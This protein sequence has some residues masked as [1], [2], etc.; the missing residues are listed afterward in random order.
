[1]NTLKQWLVSPEL[2]QDHHFVS[3]GTSANTAI[4]CSVRCFCNKL[5]WGLTHRFRKSPATIYFESSLIRAFNHFLRLPFLVVIRF[6]FPQLLMW[7]FLDHCNVLLFEVQHKILMCVLR[8]QAYHLYT[9][10]S[11]FLDI[12]IPCFVMLP[13]WC[14]F[15]HTDIFVFNVNVLFSRVTPFDSLESKSF[16]QCIMTFGE[17][18]FILHDGMNGIWKGWEGVLVQ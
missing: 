7:L 18:S 3:L 16:C 17:Y 15:N 10:I 5:K 8:L 9:N 13:N 12:N 14:L 4:L 6:L 2:L 1:M 11:P